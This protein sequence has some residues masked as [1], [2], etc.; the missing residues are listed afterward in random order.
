LLH[1]GNAPQ[2]QRQ[3]I[4]QSKELEKYFQEN[5]HKKQAGLAILVSNKTDFQPK[6]IKKR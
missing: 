6:V 5:G 4:P 3:T 2:C 1:T